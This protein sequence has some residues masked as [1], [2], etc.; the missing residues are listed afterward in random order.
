MK[1]IL[2]ILILF[3]SVVNAQEKPFDSTVGQMAAYFRGVNLKSATARILSSTSTGKVEL[4]TLG[5]ANQALRVNSAGTGVEW[6][7]PTDG[8]SEGVTYTFTN[9]SIVNS[10]NNLTLSGDAASPGN[11]MLYGTNS[12]GVKGWYA[13]PSGTNSINNS[14]TLQTSANFNIDGFG[15]AR[16]LVVNGNIPGHAASQMIGDYFSGKGRFW[17]DGADNSTMGKIGFIGSSADGSVQEEYLALESGIATFSGSILQPANS[18]RNFGATNGSSGYGIRDNSGTLE[19]K[20]SGGSWSAFGSGGTTYTG[21]TNIDVT[22]TVISTTSNVAT[23]SGAQ[24]FSGAKTFTNPIILENSA[25]A[26]RNNGFDYTI[27]PPVLSASQSVNWPNKSGTVAFTNDLHT[28]AVAVTSS[29]SYSV[30]STDVNIILTAGG[31][32]TLPTPSYNRVLYI[33]N[34]GGSTLTIAGVTGIYLDGSTS[35]SSISP[36]ASV[37]IVYSTTD[38]KWYRIY[39]HDF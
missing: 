5:T 21:S 10:S 38:S 11:S 36:T 37:K 33:T 12:S 34:N 23:L 19:F 32:I 1:R 26:F 6:Y 2:Y 3:S 13:Q 9:S 28:E 4:L 20:N 25:F 16:Y 30:A 22:G 24:T 17:S 39:Q 29:T 31:T 27:T 35:T 18:Y 15:K 7:T 8:G 14:T